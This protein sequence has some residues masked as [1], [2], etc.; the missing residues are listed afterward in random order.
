M[1]VHVPTPLRS[2]TG[3]RSPVDAAGTTLDDVLRDID[4]R[5]PGFRFRIVDEPK[6]EAALAVAEELLQGGEARHLVLFCRSE[7]GAADVGDFLTL[8]GYLAAPPGEADAPVWLAVDEL[9]ALPALESAE[10]VVVVSFDVPSGPD[11]LDRR[12][13]AGRGGLILLLA[14]ELYDAA[15]LR[16]V[17]RVTLR[18]HRRLL[19]VGNEAFPHLEPGGLHR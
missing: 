2:Y 4:R 5:H 14:R 16:D 18:L 12:H 9:G 6:E 15:Q 11:S 19:Q 10:G 13:G 17:G 1:K 3:P 8:H 7:D